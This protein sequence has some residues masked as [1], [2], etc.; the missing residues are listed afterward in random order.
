MLKWQRKYILTIEVKEEDEV[1]T[2][3][4]I[5]NP[6]TIEFFIDKNLNSQANL[7]DLKIYNLAEKTRNL[8]LQDKFNLLDF[9]SGKRYRKIVLKAGYGINTPIIFIGNLVESYSFRQGTEVITQIYAYDG[10]YGMINSYA[11]LTL[12]KGISKL[13]AINKLI[14]TLNKIDKGII[15]NLEGE[16]KRGALYNEN[17]YLL[18][19]NNF[20]DFIS[21]NN[22]VQTI[23]QRNIFVENEKINI[24]NAN[25]FIDQ[26]Y[27]IEISSNTGLLNTPKRRETFIECDILFDP[28]IIAGQLIELKSSFNKM[29]NG[30][31]KVYGFTHNVVI[32]EASGGDA[33]TTLQ[34][35][36]GTKLLNGL[37]A[38][39]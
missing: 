6:L 37:K 8:L 26:G 17:S 11:D 36:L 2:T 7:L 30:I 18:I 9:G 25:D 38:I 23:T 1:I 21:V 31:Y 5:K 24:L 27:V 3:L 19:K 35:Y 34:L 33:I 22:G 10:L 39:Q 32:S 13:D 14:S 28:N 15:T 29:F 20:K 16:L 12:S 4:E